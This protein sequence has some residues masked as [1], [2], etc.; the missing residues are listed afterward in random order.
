MW[1]L[2]NRHKWI[3]LQNRGSHWYKK[4]TYGYQREKEEGISLEIVIDIYTLLYI[5]Q[6]TNKGLLYSTENSTQYSVMA[7]MGRV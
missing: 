3:Y 4:Q 5:K 7:Y 6:I 1:N 2:K